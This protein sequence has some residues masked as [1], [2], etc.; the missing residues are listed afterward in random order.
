MGDIRML[1]EQ[2][3]ERLA[4]A[5]KYSLKDHEIHYYIQELGHY[6]LRRLAE[7]CLEFRERGYPQGKFPTVTEFEKLLKTAV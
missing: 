1:F 6:G 3:I 5:Q 2:Q 7:V 4:S